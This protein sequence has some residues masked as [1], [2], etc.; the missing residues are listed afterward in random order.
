MTES[1]SYLYEN[2]CLLFILQ[3]LSLTNINITSSATKS[4][5]KTGWIIVHI[6]VI[7]WMHEDKADVIREQVGFCKNK[8]ESYH[9]CINLEERIHAPF[10]SLLSAERSSRIP[11]FSS[12]AAVSDGAGYS[13]II[14]ITWMRI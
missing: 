13:Q 9:R 10:S 14:Q 7:P 11:C 6:L 1:S 8:L 12:I 4:N 5:A 3:P 2:V